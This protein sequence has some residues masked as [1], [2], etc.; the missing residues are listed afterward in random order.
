MEINTT[1]PVLRAGVNCLI[2]VP[3]GVHSISCVFLSYCLFYQQKGSALGNIRRSMELGDSKL[4]RIKGMG[5][6]HPLR[7]SSVDF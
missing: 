4:T 1:F 5:S 3:L 2:D 7:S 6:D